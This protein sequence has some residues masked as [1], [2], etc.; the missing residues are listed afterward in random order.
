MCVLH[1]KSQERLFGPLGVGLGGG[2]HFISE[3]NLRLCG[4][5]QALLCAITII[6]CLKCFVIVHLTCTCTFFTKGKQAN[7]E[8]V[9]YCT[10]PVV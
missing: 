4:N 10:V 1:F 6:C 3:Q 2:T 5:K 8:K 9:V 7:N